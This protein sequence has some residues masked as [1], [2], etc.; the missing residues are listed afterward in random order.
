MRKLLV[1][2]STALLL[3]SCG[4]VVWS[5]FNWHK[6]PADGHRTGVTAPSADYPEYQ[7]GVS[8]GEFYAAPNGKII[9]GGATPEVARILYEAQAEMAD[10]KTVIGHSQ[11]GMKARR[12]ESPLSNWTVDIIMEEAE[13]YTGIDVDLGIANFGG[14]R[15]EIPQ[16]DVLKDDLVSMFPFKNY[17]TVVT[18]PGWRLR[19]IFEQMAQTGVQVVGGVKLVIK[20]NQLESA[21][22]GGEPLD[23]N[24]TYNVATID[25]LLTGGDGYKLGE[26]ALQTIVTDVAV[27][28]AIL[29]R[30]QKLEAEGKTVDYQTDG[31][32][33]IIN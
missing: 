4:T 29:P 2:L 31:R 9:I 30:V 11:R 12:P 1:L 25:F 17:L 18:L 6:I 28:D 33:T 15:S 7:L 13:N 24:K 27:I 23:D 20:G 10:L 26:N 5:G 21:L 16:G 19:Q 8:N 22:V 14:I 32:V 3:S